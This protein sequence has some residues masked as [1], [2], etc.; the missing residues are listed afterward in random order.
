MTVNYTTNLALGQ[1]VTGTESGTWGDDV[2]N[3]I[4]SYLDIAIAGTLSLTSAS[5]TAN[6]LTLANTFGTS[7]A[8]NIAATTAQYYAIK[9]SSLAANVTIT[10]PLLSKTYLIINLDSTYSVTIKT[11]GQ[12][13]VAIAAGEK[14]LVYCSGAVGADY[15]KTG[16]SIPNSNGNSTGTGAVVLAVSPTLTGTP[17]APT[18]ATSTNTTQIAT[19]AFVQAV[20]QTLFPVGS[21]YSNASNSTNPATLFG[22]GTWSLFSSGRVMVGY[23][24]GTYPIGGTGGSADAT[25]V[26]HTHT[27]TASSSFSGNALGGHSHTYDTV[28]ISSTSTPGGA[29]SVPIPVA[30]TGTTSAVS[31]GTPSGSVSTSVSVTAAGSSATNANLQPYIVVYMWQRTA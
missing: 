24:G 4:T 13:G 9:V 23:D 25:L 30:T 17:L 28:G 21:I 15:I 12:S 8:T 11:A 22:F 20:L 14:I 10:A 18:A 31:A 26:S 19:T 2:N 7:S 3:S 16:A 6:A 1:P 5:F 27:A 29:Y